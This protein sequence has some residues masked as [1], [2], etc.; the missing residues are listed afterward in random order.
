MGAGDEV[1]GGRCRDDQVA[2]RDN[3][4]AA[5]EIDRAIDH[6]AVLGEADRD[7]AIGGD[8]IGI[9]IAGVAIEAG[10]QIDG[11]DKGVLFAA[12]AIDLLRRGAHRLAQQMFR[13][14]PQQ[15]V[16]DNQCRFAPK[17]F[18][19]PTFCFV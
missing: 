10:R 3:L 5:D 1:V 12:K 17:A 6:E 13:A 4:E 14:E 16:E 7:R 9:G 8:A 18:G 15:A 19:A 2:E 11:E